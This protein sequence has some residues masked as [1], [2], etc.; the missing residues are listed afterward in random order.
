MFA[1]VT[2]NTLTCRASEAVSVEEFL[3]F[4]YSDFTPMLYSEF[5]PMLL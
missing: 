4:L 5:I 2:K 3:T 1:Q